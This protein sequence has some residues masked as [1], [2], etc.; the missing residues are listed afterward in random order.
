MLEVPKVPAYAVRW[1]VNDALLV[2]LGAQV[3]AVL[4][5]GLL[6]GLGVIDVDDATTSIVGLVLG[7][8][9]LWAVYA[10]GPW[11]AARAKGAGAVADFGLSL[12]ATDIPLGL[13]VGIV[14]Q[15]VFVPL[16]YIPIGWLTD[17]DPSEAARDLIEAV[18]GSS[19][20][21]LLV[22]SAAVL[23]P[24]FEEFVYRGLLLR[25]LQRAAGPGVAAVV[26]AA[27]F[28]LVHFM[29]LQWPGLFLFGL[30]AAGLALWSG[31]LGPSVMMH[32]GF[33]ATALIGE[34]LF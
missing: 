29:V 23:A 21:W 34:G 2:I 20:R 24:L 10:L 18:D 9:G 33:N 25:A 22:L 15:L 6:I 8:L 31:R 32:V 13:G 5:A 1:G 16:L 11:W 30:L 17:E 3:V 4:W 14:A 12:R 19:T 7:N 28:A 26:S 27:L